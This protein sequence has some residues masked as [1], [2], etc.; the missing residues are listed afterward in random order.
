L[1]RLDAV[2]RILKLPFA[3]DGDSSAAARSGLPPA[4]RGHP[5][6]SLS[7][8][9]DE[10]GC[11]RIRLGEGGLP[12][13]NDQ[14][15]G[16]CFCVARV[17]RTAAC[18]ASPAVVGRRHHFWLPQPES[19]AIRCALLNASAP[20]RGC[21]QC[22][23]AIAGLLRALL[24]HVQGARAPHHCQGLAIAI[25]CL[26]LAFLTPQIVRANKDATSTRIDLDSVPRVFARRAL[27]RESPG[28]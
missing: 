8:R 19:F 15:A 22:L 4:M 23:D 28:Q 7:G 6:S 13:R 24:A 26:H 2:P 3:A 9:Q 17:L 21:K 12:P 14:H 27:T 5:A 16:A 10:P 20:L 18:T 25:R 1:T 11:P